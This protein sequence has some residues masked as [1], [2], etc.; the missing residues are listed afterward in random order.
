M[1]Y[2]KKKTKSNLPLL[3]CLLGAILMVQ[4]GKAQALM[5]LEECEAQFRIRHELFD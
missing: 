1:K 5:A 4:A 2:Y 3:I